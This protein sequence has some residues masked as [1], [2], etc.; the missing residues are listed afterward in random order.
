MVIGEP[1]NHASRF[2]ESCGTCEGTQ[3]ERVR[4]HIGFDTIRINLLINGL[5]YVNS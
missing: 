4:P 3:N 5:C 1:A 2:S